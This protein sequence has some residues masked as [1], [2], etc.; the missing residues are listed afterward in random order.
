MRHQKSARYLFAAGILASAVS[1]ALVPDVALAQA[2][3]PAIL[4]RIEML[5]AEI[6]ALKAKP[7]PAIAKQADGKPLALSATDGITIFGRVDL[8]VESNNDGRV[9]RTVIQSQKSYIGFRAQRSFSPDLAGIVQIDT[10]VAPDDNAN[11][12]S[13]ANRN[14]FVGL[15]SKSWGTILAGRHD[16][17]IKLLQGSAAPVWASA[18]V[19][20]TIINGKTM[21]ATIDGQANALTGPAKTAFQSNS[22][23][24]WGQ[25]HNRLKNVVMYQSPKFGDFNAVVEYSTDEVNGASGTYKKPTYGGLI[26]YDDKR[27]NFGIAAEKL[28]HFSAKGKDLAALKL[29]GGYRG[30]GWSVGAAYSQID[31]N[32]GRKTNNWMIAGTYKLGPTTLKANYGVGGESSSGAQDGTKMLGLEVNYPLDDNTSVYTYLA[33]MDNDKNAYG[34]FETGTNLYNTPGAGLNPRAFGLGMRYQF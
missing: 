25:F 15:R 34:R 31:N 24:K 13:F 11:S 18:D 20:E 22:A 27:W 8:G 23:N 19:M 9:N 10:T 4:K 32:A 12:T 26:Q 29:T 5:E 1:I 21:L 16:E 7:A 2:M 17:P 33:L 14:S 28:E 6:K 30:S 3:D